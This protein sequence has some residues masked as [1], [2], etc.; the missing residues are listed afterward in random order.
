MLNFQKECAEYYLCIEGEVFPF[1]CSTGLTFDIKRQICDRYDIYA[2]TFAINNAP[3]SDTVDN[4]DTSV[5][6]LVAKPLLN[7]EE[8]ICA[9][10]ET[11]CG[12]G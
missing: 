4:C 11:A 9:R 12:D 2:S 3:R 7:T 5:E 1:K 10:G 8:P 6:A